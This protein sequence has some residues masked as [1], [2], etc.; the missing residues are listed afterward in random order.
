MR[1]TCRLSVAVAIMLLCGMTSMA[2]RKPH[3]RVAIVSDLH[4][5]MPPETDQYHLVVAVNKLGEKEKIDGVIIAGDI[6]D[7]AN[8]AIQCLYRQRWE[9]G[10]GKRTI[11]YPVYP[12]FGNHD[13]SPESGRPAQNMRGFEL[14]MHYLDSLLSSMLSRHMILNLDAQS[15]SYSFEIGGVH[16]VD[17]QLCA[18][19]TSYCRSNLNW[20]ADDLRRHAADKRPVVY[21][22]HYGFDGWALY[23]WRDSD[24]K[25][26]LSILREYNLAGFFVGH[27]HSA[28]LQWYDSMP[29]VQVNN[30]WKDD[31]GP[32]S[33]VVLE[34]DGD[35][36]TIETHEVLDDKGHTRLLQ[37]VIRM[38]APVYE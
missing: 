17:G 29:I 30:A 36:V 4:F 21:I 31:D 25:S 28:S 6:F 22:Q 10:K 7:K 38:K 34:I 14:N 26:L 12:T 1:I 19:D 35:D 13:I 33:F 3:C 37:P 20:I 23:W 18:G 5:D 2:A 9:T 11:H 16:F 32:S 15:R 27:T 24:R 8:P